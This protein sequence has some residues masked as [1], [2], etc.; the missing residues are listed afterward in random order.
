MT[1]DNMR[2]P[3]WFRWMSQST[4]HKRNVARQH[5]RT[6]LKSSGCDN[7]RSLPVTIRVW[8]QMFTSRQLE[9]NCIGELAEE[10]NGVASYE[11]DEYDMDATSLYHF[12][13]SDHGPW[14]LNSPFHDDETLFTRSISDKTSALV[15]RPAN[16]NHVD[17]SFLLTGLIAAGA[18]VFTRSQIRRTVI[19]SAHRIPH[20]AV[21]FAML[22]ETNGLHHQIVTLPI[23]EILQRNGYFEPN[24]ILSS[25]LRWRNAMMTRVPLLLCM[26]CGYEALSLTKFNHQS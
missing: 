8:R 18:V 26:F 24:S 9:V 21:P 6:N 7:H 3:S 1:N 19:P 13:E 10:V 25:S 20:C 2:S 17:Q 22:V 5:Q 15:G 23:Q 11:S 16:F 14:Y 4:I 12:G